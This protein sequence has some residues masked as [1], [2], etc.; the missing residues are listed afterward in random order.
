M[1]QVV[2][3][4]II[5]GGLLGLRWWLN[6]QEDPRVKSTGRP[7]EFVRESPDNNNRLII[8]TNPEGQWTY[9]FEAF[10]GEGQWNTIKTG[11]TYPSREHAIAAVKERYDWF[12]V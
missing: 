1:G 7:N 3:L 9:V 10:V 6:R 4:A 12:L 11:G 2:T 8:F 5:I